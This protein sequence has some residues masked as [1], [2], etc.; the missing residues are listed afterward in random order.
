[1]GHTCD[2]IQWL[3]LFQCIV[4]HTLP[5]GVVWGAIRGKFGKTH[6]DYA[7]SDTGKKVKYT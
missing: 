5:K 6:S 1:M 7:W 3:G 2:I 4:R